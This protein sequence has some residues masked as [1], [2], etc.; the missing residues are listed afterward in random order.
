MTPIL[1]Q[2]TTACASLG[3]MA[4]LTYEMDA[5][6]KNNYIRYIYVVLLIASMFK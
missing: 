4:T 3:S 5:K 2:V 1:D 6:V